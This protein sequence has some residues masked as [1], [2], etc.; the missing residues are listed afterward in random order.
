MFKSFFLVVALL[1]TPK[2][3]AQ[4]SD[5]QPTARFDQIQALRLQKA[6]H[7]RPDKPPTVEKYFTRVDDFLENS[8]VRFLGGGLAQGAG[9]TLGSFFEWSKSHDRIRPKLFGTGSTR[10][11]YI[12]GTGVE[13]PHIGDHDLSITLDGLHS[14]AP[15]LD[16]YGSGPDSL[17]SNRTD[18]RREETLFESRVRFSPHRNLTS[19]CRVGQLF[20]NVGPG[21]SD[22][23]APTDSVFGPEE[24][25]GLDAQSDYVIGG[26]SAQID[27]RDFP[28]DPHVGTFFRAGYDRY[29]AEEIDRFSFNRFYAA[30]EHYIPF[31]NEKR[32]IALR[33]K[34]ELSWHAP[35]QVVPFYM[36]VT[37]GG[38]TELRGFRRYRFYDEN[39]I[40]LTGEYRWQVSTGFD[41]AMFLDAGKVFNKPSEISLTDLET[42]P[43]FGLRFKG[44]RGLVVRLD[45]G[46]SEGWHVWFRFGKLF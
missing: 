8:P 16:Y 1:L 28:N 7:L 34:T 5:A 2:L 39:S 29:Q 44:K 41:M 3:M 21:T 45:T 37:L 26:C 14:D 20:L 24:A 12:A 22:R 38:D 36:Q 32:V 15:Q 31:L 19:A 13:L 17:K 10:L 27:L 40:V 46:V 30:A 25:P 9:F 4:S 6:A 35:D 23:I 11:Y 42:S 33:A 18:Y 43:G